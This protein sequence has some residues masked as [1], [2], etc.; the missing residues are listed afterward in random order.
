MAGIYAHIPF[1]H[2]KCAYCDFYSMPRLKNAERLIEALKSE[3]LLRVSELQDAPIETLYLGG[4][5]PSIIDPQ[6]LSSFVKTIP[7]DHLKEVTIE[8]NPE[9]VDLAKA[10]AWRS[11]GFNRA[12]MGVQ[13]LVDAELAN[14]GRR[15]SASEAMEAASTLRKAG[16]DNLSLDLI[17]GLP[18]QTAESWQY[19]LNKLLELKPTHISAY[20]LTYEP[21]TRLTAMRNR[22]LISEASED[23]ILNYYGM[24]CSTLRQ[25]GYDHYEISNFALPGMEA[26]HNS[27]YWNYVPYLGLGPSAHSFDG[28]MRSYNPA[29][30]N[31]Y[32]KCIERGKA[33]SIFEEE[34][35]N[36]RFNDLLITSLRTKKGLSLSRIDNKRRHQLMADA[37]AYLR[38]G[39]LILEDDALQIPEPSWLISDSILASLI[40]I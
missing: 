32:L 5:T 29:N 27:S 37:D 26:M 25:H 35:E 34:D 6:I 11:M 12:S 3:F 31:D 33:A 20:T 18:G 4:G 28:T 19:S 24:L 8:V 40:Q 9:D 16:F 21:R 10:E 13:S 14:I 22:G 17:Y 36:N 7:T 15:H 30:L 1:C 38:S 23:D 39:D 2:S